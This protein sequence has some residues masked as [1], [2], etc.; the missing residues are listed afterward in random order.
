MTS[1]QMDLTPSQSSLARRLWHDGAWGGV[2]DP[3]CVLW[4]PVN[5]NEALECESPKQAEDM[6]VIFIRPVLGN[7]VHVFQVVFP[8]TELLAHK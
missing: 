8:L 6:E 5:G 2:F 7:S 3:E 4:S 1:M